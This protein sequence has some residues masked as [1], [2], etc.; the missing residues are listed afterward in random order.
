MFEKKP[1]HRDDIIKV[2]REELASARLL[3]TDL[4][5]QNI[6]LTSRGTYRELYPKEKVENGPP[7]APV[8]N[9]EDPRKVVYKPRVSFDEVAAAMAKRELKEN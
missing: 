4:V 3:I 1:D 6:A 9:W 7:P 2:L 8:E 5:K